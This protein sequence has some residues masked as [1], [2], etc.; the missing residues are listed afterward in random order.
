MNLLFGKPPI[1][2]RNAPL[3]V[4]E[5]DKLYTIIRTNDK[6]KVS[7]Q[8]VRKAATKEEQKKIKASELPYL[9]PFKYKELVRNSKNFESADCMFFEADH[10]DNLADVLLKVERHPNVCFSYTS[11]SG[12]GFK[13]CVMLDEAISEAHHLRVYNILRNKFNTEWSIIL[14]P[15][16]KDLARVQYL[17]HDPNCFMNLKAK[18]IESSKIVARLKQLDSIVVEREDS[19]EEPVY[20][21]TEIEKAIRHARSHGFLDKKDEQTWWELSMALASLGEA[22]RKYFLQLSCDNPNYPEDTVEKL[23]KRWD[24]FMRAWGTY[25]DEERILNVSAFFNKIEKLYGYKAPRVSTAGKTNLEL[26]LRDKLRVMY[27]GQLLYD[28]SKTGKGKTYGWYLWDGRRFAEGDKAQVNEYY[29]RLIEDEKRK[30]IEASAKNK[31]K[32]SESLGSYNDDEVKKAKKTEGTDCSLE[33]L[34]LA[35]ISKSE[36][37]KMRDLALSWLTSHEEFA[38]TIADF[39]TDV[40]KI[41][42]ANGVLKLQN[43]PTTKSSLVEHDPKFRCT[44]ISETVFD[45]KAKCHRWEQFVLKICKGNTELVRYLQTAVGYSLTGKTD[46]HCLFFLYGTGA[47]GKSTFLEGLKLVFGEYMTHAN[48]ETFTSFGREG[49]SASPDVVRLRGARMVVSTEMA[50]DKPLNESMVKQITSGEVIT[51]RALHSSFIE[52][53]PTFKL[54]IAGN[55][56][57]RLQNFDAGIRRRIN[58]IPFEYQFTK[59]EIRPQ[60]DVVEE[61]RQEA[62]GILNWCLDGLALY[63]KNKKLIDSVAVEDASMNF[64]LEANPVEQFLKDCCELVEDDAEQYKGENRMNKDF[65]RGV[66]LIDAFTEW[67]DSD[68]DI[69]KMGRN[70]F[71][72]RLK[73]KGFRTKRLPTVGQ[74]FWGLKLKTQ[75]SKVTEKSTLGLNKN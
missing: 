16:S 67:Q 34:T 19:D 25:H 48:Y 73:E 13:F 75:R 56:M 74:V 10:V 12:D 52:F 62:S 35:S 49:G 45:P 54:W 53:R 30:A 17:A 23:N 47:N 38:S 41:N 21:E 55:H 72:S 61:F 69:E 66:E 14:D 46:A 51:A 27:S 70:K 3:T 31:S 29:L 24:T 43:A 8:R 36:T 33:P 40:S 42:L 64:F 57:P 2:Q 15:S 59:E 6:L 44:K 65:V 58:I 11:V 63:V 37:M 28:H 32:E 7:T 71:Y 18:P 50:G 1:S 26:V 20:D 39:D 5:L 4:I 60:S 9:M 22:G 68:R